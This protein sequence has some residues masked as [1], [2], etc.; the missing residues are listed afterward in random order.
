VDEGDGST[1][2]SVGRA[3]VEGLPRVDHKD[4]RPAQEEE[5]DDDQEHADDALLGHE[6]GCGAVAEHSPRRG[7]AA[8]VC[9][10]ACTHY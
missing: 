5:K 2:E 8:G 7:G 3:T 10:G 4:G 6:V 1:G 9:T